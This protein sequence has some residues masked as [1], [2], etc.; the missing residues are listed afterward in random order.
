MLELA[1]ND[2][3]PVLLPFCEGKLLG[4]YLA[5]RARCYK[6]DYD[7][8]R[9]WTAYD[10]GVTAA[11]GAMDSTAIVLADA[12]ADFEEL[13][14]FLA[15]QGFSSVMTDETTAAR[16]GLTVRQTKTAFRFTGRIPPEQNAVSDADMQSVYHLIAES[17]PGS[18]AGTKEAYLRFLSDFTFRKNRG[19]ARMCAVTEG[20]AVL[21]TALT[22]AETDTAAVISGVAV[23]ASERGKGYGKRVVRA[24]LR[25]LA[26]DG[27]TADVIALNPSAEAFYRALGFA[28]LQKICDCN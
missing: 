3:L 21:A 7:F 6:A 22:A 20:D 18:F 16:C 11:V 12:T 24:M 14:C 8:V 19:A 2:S 4:T 25:A 26:L 27:K 15:M 9:I 17:I 13:G 5:C 1:T 28:E 23:R 10:G